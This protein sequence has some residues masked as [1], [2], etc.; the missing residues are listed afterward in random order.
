MLT[1][2]QKH[3][4]RNL[5][6]KICGVR[7]LIA[8]YEAKKKELSDQL[9][10]LLLSN[11]EEKWAD[12]RFT[13]SISQKKRETLDKHLL[14]ANGVDTDVI[15]RSTKVTAWTETIVREKKEKDGGA[16]DATA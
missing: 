6:A 12:D 15:Q 3:E 14:V 1:D 13:V 9:A 4:A 2:E 7:L 8:E 5:S 10:L 16:E 11:G